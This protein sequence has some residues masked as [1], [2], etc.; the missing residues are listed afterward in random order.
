MCLLVSEYYSELFH[1]S[2]KRTLL[3]HLLI[4]LKTQERHKCSRSISKT[5]ASS[6]LKENRAVGCEMGADRRDYGK[7]LWLAISATIRAQCD[8]AE[9]LV[10]LL[11]FPVTAAHQKAQVSYCCNQQKGSVKEQ[12]KSK[13]LKP[14]WLAVPMR[15]GFATASPPTLR[16]R[17]LTNCCELHILREGAVLCL[18]TSLTMLRVP[19]RGVIT[20]GRNNMFL[21][22]GFISR[23]YEH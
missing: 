17:L 10:V 16:S 9:G 18:S 15:D 1:A 20:P 21:E 6:P 23:T 12:K 2:F 3:I 19:T 4:S 7:F 22:L 5:S 11:P 14:P 13:C 8:L